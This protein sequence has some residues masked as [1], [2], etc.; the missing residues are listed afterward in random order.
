MTRSKNVVCGELPLSVVMLPTLLYLIF[1]A[2]E[3]G[4]SPRRFW[5]DTAALKRLMLQGSGLKGRGVV[6]S[7]A[8]AEVVVAEVVPLKAVVVDCESGHHVASDHDR[9]NRSLM[10]LTQCWFCQRQLLQ[11]SHVTA[12]RRRPGPPH[13]THLRLLPMPAG[14][15]FVVSKTGRVVVPG[16]IVPFRLRRR[17]LSSLRRRSLSPFP[18]FCRRQPSPFLLRLPSGVA[19]SPHHRSLPKELQWYCAVWRHRPSDCRHDVQLPHSGSAEATNTN[20]KASIQ[21][22]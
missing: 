8:G 20:A 10:N 7:R 9:Q 12:C 13:I 14:R 3:S 18:P 15:G 5:W 4:P 21:A 19:E 1:S 17:W 16:T 11:L 6:E 22:R 2:P